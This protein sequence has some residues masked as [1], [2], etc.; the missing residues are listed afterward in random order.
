MPHR[1]ILIQLKS[2]TCSTNDE[3]FFCNI[4]DWSQ[5][6]RG[7]VDCPRKMH[8]KKWIG[9][10]MYIYATLH[11]LSQKAFPDSH[12][13]DVF[14]VGWGTLTEKLCTTNGQGP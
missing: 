6:W 1:S 13:D 3:D 7:L 11:L 10:T 9:S 4:G 5:N 8:F 12:M 2:I 14:V